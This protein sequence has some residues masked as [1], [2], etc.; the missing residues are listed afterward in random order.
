MKIA[1]SIR[2]AVQLRLLAASLL[3]LGLGGLVSAQVQL[4]SGFNFGQFL[5]GGEPVTDYAGG[6]FPTVGSISSNFGGSI[7]PG[8]QDGGAY[9]FA[10]AVDGTFTAGNSILYFD[11][12]NGSG[13]FDRFGGGTAGS[14]TVVEFAGPTQYS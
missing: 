8:P 7:S 2:L 4:I 5:Y 6:S 9:K 10:N 13:N 14:V 3:T 12:T 11:G 1:S